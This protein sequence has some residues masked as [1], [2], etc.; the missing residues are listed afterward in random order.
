[1]PQFRSLTRRSWL[2]SGMAAGLAGIGWR[3][4]AKVTRGD[5][6]DRP[7]AYSVIPVV[8][9]GR[10]I[11]REPPQDERGYLEP[12]SYKLSIGIQ[13]EGSGS[14]SDLT[15]TTTVPVEFPEQKIDD[16]QLKTSGCE[17][18]LRKL[19]E[20]SGQLLLSAAAIEIGQVVSA[21]AEYRLTL[22]KQYQAYD[23]ERF[24]VKQQVPIEI[25]RSYLQ[26][27]PGI[28]T[29]SKPVRELAAELTAKLP[30]L[31]HPWDLAKAFADWVPA[32]IRPQIGDYTSVTA[33]LDD[34]RGDCEEMAG[35]FVALCRASGIPA[36]LVWVPNHT[37]TEFY[38]VD[39]DG[40]AHWV[41]AH[42][43]CYPWFGFN[44]AHELVLQKG[45]RILLPERR[46]LL[47]L[48]PDWTQFSGARPRVSYTAE[49][50][51]LPPE[52][53]G[54]PGPGARRK[55]EK[56]EWGVFGDHPLD[57]YLRR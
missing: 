25:R 9:D 44:G 8:G 4:A 45:D 36:R 47:R 17:A 43:A 52:S 56:G 3:A 7:R 12:R 53:G 24:P 6:M 46:K 26:D 34:R 23:R 15:S 37:W 18:R 32:N 35:I 39:H 33:A 48:L 41:P 49:L 55:D 2:C 20:G 51:P 16:V 22:F 38:L 42:T 30:T 29:R 28:Q 19:S 31:K 1:M 11:W 5:R 14:A 54:D 13:L 57:R 21:V 27:S 40:A 10:W 50:V